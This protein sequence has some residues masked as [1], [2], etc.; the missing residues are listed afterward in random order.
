LYYYRSR[1]QEVQ[2]DEGEDKKDRSD[3]LVPMHILFVRVGCVMWIKWRLLVEFLSSSSQ[4]AR[5]LSVNEKKER[6]VR[7]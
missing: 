2:V 5:A 3:Y 6:A 4:G 1:E 7:I